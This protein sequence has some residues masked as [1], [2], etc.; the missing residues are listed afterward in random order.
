MTRQIGGS[1]KRRCFLQSSSLAIVSSHLALNGLADKPKIEQ[2]QSL[3]DGKTLKG[4]KPIPRLP[5]PQPLSVAKIPSNELKD[6]VIAWHQG[7]PEQRARLEH[8]GRW[9]VVDGAIVGGHEPPESLHGAYLISE[10]KF[11]DF[12]LELEARPDWPVDTGIMIRAHELG[13]VG[14]QVLLDHRPTGG[15]AGVF[16]NSIGNF[17]AAP[18]TL[19]G[20]KLPNFQ[21]ANLREGERESKFN[22]PK[23]DY[24]ATFSD[25]AKIWHENDWNHFRIRCVGRLPT[26]TTWVNGMKI[27]EFDTSKIDT[28]GF[29]AEQVAERLGRSGHIAFEVHDV[30]LNKPLGQDRWAPGAVCRWRNIKI[31]E[32]S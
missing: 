29:D 27:C 2:K 9:E 30:N 6:A 28:P 5:I 14:F 10:Q 1:V 7:K 22:A 18:F 12:E 26:I 23:M 32:L 20:D 21:V 25:F 11:A 31:T 13:S 24:E 17:L 19:D 15:V 4:W 8:T 3:F 16:G